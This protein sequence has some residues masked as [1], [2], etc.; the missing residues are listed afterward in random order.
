V[1]AE[2]SAVCRNPGRM[3]CPGAEDRPPGRMRRP[4]RVA[5]RLLSSIEWFVVGSVATLLLRFS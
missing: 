5:R 3:G 2:G 4:L 1:R